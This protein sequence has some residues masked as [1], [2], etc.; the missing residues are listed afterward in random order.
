MTQTQHVSHRGWL[1]AVVLIALPTVGWAQG[2]E[3]TTAAAQSESPAERGEVQIGAG[4]TAAVTTGS[5][6]PSKSSN[7]ALPGNAAPFSITPPQDSFHGPGMLPLH[8]PAQLRC[9]L[10]EDGNAR[11]RCTAQAAR[12]VQGGSGD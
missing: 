12:P 10:I 11:K 4:S 1:L 7:P 8:A 6:G 3:A 9:D 2:N 5:S